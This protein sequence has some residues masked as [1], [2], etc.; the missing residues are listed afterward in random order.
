MARGRI[1]IGT[2]GFSYKDW[3]GNF[4]P[5][6]CP[7]QDFLRLYAHRFDTVEID[8]TFYRIPTEQ[9]VR[10]WNEQT[11]AGFLFTAKFPKVVTHEGDLESRLDNAMRF[12]E[13]MSVLGDKLG[14]LLLQF[15]YSFKPDQVD[16]LA[17]LLD[18]LPRD[19]KIAVEFRNK[20]WLKQNEPFQTMRE[21]NR[22]LCL[23]DHPWMPRVQSAVAD[24]VYMRFIGDRKKIDGNFTYLRQDRE[25]DLQWWAGV[26]RRLLD[27]GHDVFAY[28]NNH[29]TGH[30]PTTAARMIDIL[31]ANVR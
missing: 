5:Q 8:S 19:S 9:M 12:I 16:L 22:A 30:S 17:R 2:S 24:F 26:I 23:I 31:T 13:V 29:Y 15:P 4:Y 25:E 28:F 20:G 21:Q 1:R 6:F 10:R 7:Q 18:G 14:P 27:E 3:L 11:S